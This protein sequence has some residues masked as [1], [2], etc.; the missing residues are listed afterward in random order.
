MFGAAVANAGELAASSLAK[1]AKELTSAVVMC[2]NDFVETMASIPGVDVVSLLGRFRKVCFHR[3]AM[4]LMALGVSAGGLVLTCTCLFRRKVNVASIA[5]DVWQMKL[6]KNDREATTVSVFEDILY[7][8]D[9][10]MKRMGEG[11]EPLYSLDLP[12][13]ES[14]IAEWT[15]SAEARVRVV[16]GFAGSGKTTVLRRLVQHVVPTNYPN[17]QICTAVLDPI[18]AARAF[19]GIGKVR[20]TTRS[21]VEWRRALGSV[22][23]RCVICDPQLL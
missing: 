7:P 19:G 2:D 10:I 14:E 21:G 16:E 5:G 15:A 8:Q 23:V 17:V 13:V 3:L 1:A 6:E 11:R 22:L 4:L 9:I 12:N 18:T 20:G